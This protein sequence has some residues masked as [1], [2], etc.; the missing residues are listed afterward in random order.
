MPTTTITTSSSSFSVLRRAF[1]SRTA[2]AVHALLFG[3]ADPERLR[4]LVAFTRSRGVTFV[5]RAV[6]NRAH[7]FS[8]LKPAASTNTTTLCYASHK[9]RIFMRAP[10]GVTLDALRR[11]FHPIRI[12]T[13]DLRIPPRP[14]S[15]DVLDEW[16]AWIDA[17]PPPP[18]ASAPVALLLTTTPSM[19]A[20]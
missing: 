4:A 2:D 14:G 13:A 16:W 19:S 20:A 15:R 18:L 9:L 8:A 11:D 1:P 17:R 10:A 3:T 12:V 7:R 5:V 6:A